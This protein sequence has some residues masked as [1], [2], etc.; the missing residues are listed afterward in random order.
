M[1]RVHVGRHVARQLVRA[2]AEPDEQR[3]DHEQRQRPVDDPRDRERRTRRRRSRSRRPARSRRP[4][5]AMSADSRLAPTAAPRTTAAPGAPLSAEVPAISS[6]AIEA[7]VAAAMWPVDPSAT[8]TTSV[9]SARSGAVGRARP[10]SGDPSSGP[11]LGRDELGERR[12]DRGEARRS[13]RGARKW[14]AMPWMWTG[15]AR[16]SRSRPRP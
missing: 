15:S 8:P 14:S 6:A 16:W 9:R 1:V 10:R 2:V 13:P 3:A 7:T 4:R 5:R 11:A 12:P